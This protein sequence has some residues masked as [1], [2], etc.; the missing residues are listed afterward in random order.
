MTIPFP[1]DDE[2]V[3]CLP[4]QA[5]LARDDI[6]AEMAPRPG[7]IIQPLPQSPGVDCGVPY[8]WHLYGDSGSPYPLAYYCRNYRECS[9]CLEYKT[10]DLLG[11]FQRIFRYHSDIVIEVMNPAWA[12]A[13][14]MNLEQHAYWKNPLSARETL[15]TYLPI[16]G[17]PILDNR[18]RAICPA[19]AQ[20][21]QWVLCL[22]K[23]RKQ[24]MSGTLGKGAEYSM[25]GYERVRVKIN[26]SEIAAPDVNH[27]K[28][29]K[30][31]QY[32]KKGIGIPEHIGMPSEIEL[33]Y[34][35]YINAVAERL[36]EEGEEVT[37]IPKQQNIT[38]QR[39]IAQS[40]I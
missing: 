37:V 22:E 19:R 12:Y 8:I 39:P 21:E 31:Y 32:C 10:D 13:V 24:K 28:V 1:G 3:S 25:P 5:V 36:R 18:P 15:V 20:V 23:G 6:H 11:R 2:R 35:L 16:T 14:G 7:E 40:N 34:H 26:I 4:R 17:A 29:R 27:R 9:V 33:G 30:A 38:L